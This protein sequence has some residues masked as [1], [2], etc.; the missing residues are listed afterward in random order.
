MPSPRQ[1]N[2]PARGRVAGSPLGR[3]TA[4]AVAERPGEVCPHFH[5]AIE[6]VGKRWSGA[7]V[8][9]LGDG[10]VRFGELSRRVPGVSDRLL[11]RRLRE[12]EDWGLVERS[13]EEGAPVRVSYALT[14]KGADLQPTLQRLREW[15]IRWH[16]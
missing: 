16:T 10:P 9:A 12:L 11:S 7:I 6:L 15:A 13:V 1:S 2:D 4:V 3:R 8:W 14:E 5:T